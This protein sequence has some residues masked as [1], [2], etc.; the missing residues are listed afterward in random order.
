MMCVCGHPRSDHVTVP[1]AAEA[2]CVAKVAGKPGYCPCLDFTEE[3]T[4][5]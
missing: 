2:M 3:G 1:G 4:E 5:E